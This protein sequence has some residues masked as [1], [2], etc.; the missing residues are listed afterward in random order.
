MLAIS[1]NTLMTMVIVFP[2]EMMGKGLSLLGD[3]QQRQY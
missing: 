1:I 2:D 3:T